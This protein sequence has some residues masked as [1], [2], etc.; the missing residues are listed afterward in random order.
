MKIINTYTSCGGIPQTLMERV[1]E[2][3]EQAVKAKQEA[4]T[5]QEENKELRMRME[6]VSTEQ[7]LA[8]LLRLAH[9]SSIAILQARGTFQRLTEL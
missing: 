6:Q 4:S 9:L 2:F 1:Y 5:Q 7:L 3:R 8:S